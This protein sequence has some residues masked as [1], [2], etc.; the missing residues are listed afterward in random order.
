MEDNLNF[1][2][3]KSGR[4]DRKANIHFFD[5]KIWEMLISSKCNE[6]TTVPLMFFQSSITSEGLLSWTYF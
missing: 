3:Q 1:T 2:K 5:I 6:I 4:Q